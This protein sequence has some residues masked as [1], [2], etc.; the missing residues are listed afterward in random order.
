MI[1]SRGLLSVVVLL[2]YLSVE[3]HDAVAILP[4]HGLLL[5]NSLEELSRTNIL[6]LPN[7]IGHFRC[8]QQIYA[9]NLRVPQLVNP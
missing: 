4:L 7:S 9:V 1:L 3:A 5:A 8:R 2:S 6:A